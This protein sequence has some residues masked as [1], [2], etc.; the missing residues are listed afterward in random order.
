MQQ[1]LRHQNIIKQ[2]YQ[3]F[4]Q[5][6]NNEEITLEQANTVLSLSERI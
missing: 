5:R 3:L 2:R 6:Y 1:E 4:N